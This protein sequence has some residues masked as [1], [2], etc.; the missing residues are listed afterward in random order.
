MTWTIGLVIINSPVF[1]LLSLAGILVHF[2]P[3]GKKIYVPQYD[4]Y[5]MV[6]KIEYQVLE[7]INVILCSWCLGLGI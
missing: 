1:F 2:E 4:L 3:S 7:N 5:F 6:E